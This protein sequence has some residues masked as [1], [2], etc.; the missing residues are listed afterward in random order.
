MNYEKVSCK[1]VMMH[2]CDSLG[3]DLNSEK[4]IAI[5]EHLENCE[6]CTN[7]FKSVEMTIDFYKKYNAEIPQ[8]AH[9]RLMDLLG[10]K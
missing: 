6:G 7:Y 3:E 9:D 1:D 10:L 4:C 8:T 2:V 5:K